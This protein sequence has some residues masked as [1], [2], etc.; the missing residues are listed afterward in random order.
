MT[1]MFQITRSV[2]LCTFLG[3]FFHEPSAQELQPPAIN[4]TMASAAGQACAKFTSDGKLLTAKAVGQNLQLEITLQSKPSTT[5]HLL[6]GQAKSK[7]N[8][9]LEGIGWQP[10]TI[11]VDATNRLAAVGLPIMVDEEGRKKRE[12]FVAVVNLMTNEWGPQHLVGYNNNSVMF[13]KLIGFLDESD[14]LLVVTD[15]LFD[16][17]PRFDSETIDACT[18][19]VE[20]QQT[21]EV[22]QFAP[23]LRFFFDARNN[24]VWLESGHEKS[25]KH[26]LHSV[27]LLDIGKVGPSV[28]LTKLHHDHWLPDWGLVGAMAFPSSSTILLADSGT[29]MGFGPSHL[30]VVCQSNGSVRVVDLPKDI[31]EVLLHGLGL[32][33]FEDVGSPAVL[34]PD[35]RFL[36]VPITLTTTGPP[37]IVDNYVSVGVRFVI[38]DLM[39]LRI[40]SSVR[41]KDAR[42]SISFALDH[43]DGKVTLVVSA[44][45]AWKRLEFDAPE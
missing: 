16:G 45:D 2:V 13:P 23:I 6:L 43:R 24:R 5:L 12:T 25:K 32:N 41:L 4:G 30:W 21:V 36:A 14:R 11:S 8:L 42:E 39:R 10:C 1:A 20:N 18:G 31:G 27:S 37:Y 29:S 19:E 44:N 17:L 28:D 38:V 7:R 3:A 22:G 34:S 15:F 40:V 9:T 35:G 26:T 33:W